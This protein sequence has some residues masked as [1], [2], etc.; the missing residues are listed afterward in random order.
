MKLRLPIAIA[1]I[2]PLLTLQ[3]SRSSHHTP[4]ILLP[5]LPTVVGKLTVVPPF[6]PVFGPRPFLALSYGL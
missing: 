5:L 2:V 6:P 3:L 1:L 4:S